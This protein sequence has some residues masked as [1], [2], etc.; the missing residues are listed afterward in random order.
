[1]AHSCA[2]RKGMTPGSSRCTSAP[3]ETKSSAPPARI[4]RTGFIRKSGP[5]VAGQR[6]PD[7]HQIAILQAELRPPP[8]E[9]EMMTAGA[10]VRIAAQDDD[11]A[12]AVVL[13][14]EAKAIGI[15]IAAIFQDHARA[16]A[17]RRLV[18][19]ARFAGQPSHGE[20]REFAVLHRQPRQRTA[21]ADDFE[22]VAG[23]AT[24]NQIA[25]LQ[26]LRSLAG[27]ALYD[28]E[29]TRPP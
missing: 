21:A 13:G 10:A 5:R 23:A 7:Y 9:L 6:R 26:A 15:A 25:E 22:D 14:R 11:Q 4:S 17:L 19:A 24:Q 18:H 28:P 29:E 8:E 3:S 16:S 12:F 1:M 2:L 20:G 27:H